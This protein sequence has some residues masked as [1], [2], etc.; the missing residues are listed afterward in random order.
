MKTEILEMALEER[1]CLTQSIAINFNEVGR[2]HLDLI[3]NLARDT[4]T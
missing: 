4:L 3:E 1:A 2:A